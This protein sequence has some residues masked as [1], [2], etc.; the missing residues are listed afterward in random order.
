MPIRSRPVQS[1]ADRAVLFTRADLVLVLIVLIVIQA[2][3]VDAGMSVA[4]TA[5]TLLALALGFRLLVDQLDYAIIVFGVLQVI[6]GSDSVAGSLR[7][8]SQ[9]EILLM[10]LECVASYTD[11]RTV[12]VESLVSQ[13]YV[14]LAPA[15]IVVSPA[16]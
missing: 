16:A 10:H 9:G 4:V 7:I 15:T 14:A 11:I 6:F 12:T 2:V 3:A 8:A 5:G 13:R 1:G